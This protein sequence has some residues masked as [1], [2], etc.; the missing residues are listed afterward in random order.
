MGLSLRGYDP[1]E[2]ET[3]DLIVEGLDSET[4]HY[5]VEFDYA[6]A[7]DFKATGNI[8]YDDTEEV[9]KWV[10]LEPVMSTAEVPVV[11]TV[12]VTYTGEDGSLDA[13]ISEQTL[14]ITLKVERETVE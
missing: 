2:S 9:W 5:A 3:V 1:A 8:V 10:A 11:L 7:E 14:N 6:I 12:K 13:V 4:D